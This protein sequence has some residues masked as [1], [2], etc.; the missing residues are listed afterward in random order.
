MHMNRFVE[1]VNNS[2][3]KPSRNNSGFVQGFVVATFVR[4]QLY[5]CLKAII[6]LNVITL[7]GSRYGLTTDRLIP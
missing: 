5:V 4:V 2:L 1:R 6:I 7:Q 3:A